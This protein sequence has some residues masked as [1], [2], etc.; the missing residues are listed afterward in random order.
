M[1]MYLTVL[2]MLRTVLQVHWNSPGGRGESPDCNS[3]FLSFKGKGMLSG[4][5]LFKHEVSFKERWMEE[6]IWYS[7]W[8]SKPQFSH[9]DE[10][11]QT[12]NQCLASGWFPMYPWWFQKHNYA[13][14]KM[15]G[16]ADRRACLWAETTGLHLQTKGH[17][18]AGLVEQMITMSI[19]G[20]S[21][22]TRLPNIIY[23]LL[24]MSLV[25]PWGWRWFIAWGWLWEETE[26]SWL[27][28][29]LLQ[30]EV[31]VFMFMTSNKQDHKKRVF[32]QTFLPGVQMISVPAWIEV[33]PYIWYMS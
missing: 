33:V 1:N 14:T 7:Q 12:H 2:C 13:L 19:A 3:M 31:T 22:W 28:E 30:L 16:R 21:L 11:S 5:W 29:F 27:F 9:E 32:L 4:C 6:S 25:N 15:L 10:Q 8:P 23:L 17:S 20:E 24:I 26:E 18:T